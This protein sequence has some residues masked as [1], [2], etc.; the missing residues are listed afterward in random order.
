MQTLEN[1]VAFSLEM[2]L[3]SSLIIRRLAFTSQSKINH[4]MANL[5][6]SHM[7][8]IEKRNC[9]QLQSETVRPELSSMK[10]LSGRNKLTD[11]LLHHQGRNL[12]VKLFVEPDNGDV[13]Y[14]SSVPD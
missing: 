10:L 6:L 13:K 9:S 14:C 12:S 3:E 4:S 5:L 8:W 2:P 1:M 7:L 11:D